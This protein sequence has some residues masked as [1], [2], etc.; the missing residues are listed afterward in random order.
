MYACLVNYFFFFRE[1][2]SNTQCML[3]AYVKL[4]SQLMGLLK[5]GRKSCKAK[6][7]IGTCNSYSYSIYISM[8]CSGLFGAEHTMVRART[9]AI[10]LVCSEVHAHTMVCSSL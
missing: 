8:V 10:A 7:Y 2:G 6:R 5:R 4:E 1:E 9:I 3:C